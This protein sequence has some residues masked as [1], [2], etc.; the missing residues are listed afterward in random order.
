MLLGLMLRMYAVK[1]NVVYVCCKV[2]CRL[3]M[4]LGEMSCMYAVR[5][6]VAP[7][8]LLSLLRLSIFRVKVTEASAHHLVTCSCLELSFDK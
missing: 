7:S 2:K 8:I 6:H 3:C 5:R 1:C 4:L